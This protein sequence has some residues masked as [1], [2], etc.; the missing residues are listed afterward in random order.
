MA[1]KQ[2]PLKWVAPVVAAALAL[3]ALEL[4]NR[5]SPPAAWALGTVVLVAVVVRLV[6]ISRSE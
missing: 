4:T 5:F 1:R 2:M 6:V 3:L